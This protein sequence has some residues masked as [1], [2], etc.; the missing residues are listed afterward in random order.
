MQKKSSKETIG[1]DASNKDHF[2]F[3]I[4][5]QIKFQQIE[6]KVKVALIL[7]HRGQLMLHPGQK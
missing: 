1:H 5:S 4:L 6:K 3:V 2:D 7:S